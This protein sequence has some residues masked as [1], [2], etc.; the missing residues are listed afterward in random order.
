MILFVRTGALG[1]F[2]LTLPVLRALFATG[3]RVDLMCQPRFTALLD[4]VGEPGRTWDAESAASTWLFGAGTPPVAYR[5]AVAFSSAHAEALRAIGVPEVH[6]VASRPPPGVRA[7]DH[8]EGAWPCASLPSRPGRRGGREVVIAPGASEARRRW[9]MERWSEVA[10]EVER[11]GF[12]V[13]LVGGPQE[14]W[15][16]D[17]PDLRGLLA[18]ARSCRAWLGADSGPAHVAALGGAPVGLVVRDESTAWAPRGASCF[19]WDV[20]PADL[21]AGMLDG[22]DEPPVSEPGLGA[23][24]SPRRP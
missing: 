16:T 9:P 13:R 19:G 7:A 20:A 4:D 3:R 21:V 17:R 5:T 8:F 24:W 6:A 14:A 12:V 11:R 23:G 22:P 1:D 18:L 2:C 10:A 15:A